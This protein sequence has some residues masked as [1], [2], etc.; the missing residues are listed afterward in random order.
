MSGFGDGPTQRDD[1]QRPKNQKEW[2]LIEKMLLSS[3]NENRKQRRW[4][5][6]FRFVTFGYLFILLFLFIPGRTGM[7]PSSTEPHTGLV[8]VNGVIAESAE[9]SADRIATGLRRA[10]EAE[11][12][13]AVIIKINSPGGS[14]VQAGMVYREIKR[15]REEYPDKKVYAAITDMGASGGYYIASAAD[16]IYADPSSIVGSIGVIMA[17]FGFTDAIDKLGVDR[18]VLTAGE[19]KALMD[20]FKPVEESEQAHVQDM[21]DEIH[22]QFITAVRE[23]RGDRLVNPEENKLFS[24]LFWTGEKAVDLGLADGLASP[25][26]VARDIIGQEEIVDYTPRRSPFEQFMR[27]FGASVGAGVAGALGLEQAR[28]R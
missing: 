20:P 6:F 19:N 2:Q 5:I 16:E 11:N 18:R 4:N 8:A 23:G 17:G 1:D 27:E 13:K 3:Q 28:L 24:G 21:L 12:S 25:G 9:A 10:F 22:D 15:L 14:P 7:A 26:Q